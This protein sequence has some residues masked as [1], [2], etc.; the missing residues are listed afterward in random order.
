MNWQSVTLKKRIKINKQISKLSNKIL[1][2][3]IKINTS[4]TP[5]FLKIT[6]SKI[7]PLLQDSNCSIIDYLLGK[8][9]HIL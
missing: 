1:A 7:Q 3:Y 4:P 9:P 6:S 5:I 2:L 8:S